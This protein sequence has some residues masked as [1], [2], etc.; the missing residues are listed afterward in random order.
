M[1]LGGNF[2][3]YYVGIM[4][5]DHLPIRVGNGIFYSV[6]N[7]LDRVVLLFLL[8][9]VIFILRH[10]ISLQAKARVSIVIVAA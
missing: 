1:V 6:Y 10:E 8:F 5:R 7:F 9:W 2:E 3:I 4:E